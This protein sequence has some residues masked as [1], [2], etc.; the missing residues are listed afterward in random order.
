MDCIILHQQDHLEI[1]SKLERGDSMLDLSTVLNDYPSP[2]FVI[3]P[4][5][6]GK[7]Q[8]FIYRFVNKAFCIFIGR[9]NNELVNHRFLSIFPSGETVWFDAFYRTVQTKKILIVNE[10]SDLIE[11]RLSVELFP[12]GEKY[13]GCIIHSY[14]DSKSDVQMT[15]I[16]YNNLLHNANTDALT[17]LYNRHYLNEVSSGYCQS[18]I[19]AGVI[20]L[21]INNLKQIN[22]MHGHLAGDKHILRFTNTINEWFSPSDVYRIGG[23][24]FLVINCNMSQDVFLDHAAKFKEYLSSNGIAAIGY[25]Y[26]ENVT[27]IEECISYCD[28]M[29]YKHK[30]LTKLKFAKR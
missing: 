28:K 23:D 22:D 10:V 7:E 21:D 30:I 9:D 11:K 16:E 13:C 29:M 14:T 18:P 26:F 5:I 8:D 4:I 1:K 25:G 19:D 3:E 27:N 12:I 6:G 20:F 24:E 15:N 17:G 2:L